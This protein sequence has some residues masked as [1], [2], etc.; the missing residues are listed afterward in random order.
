[1]ADDPAASDLDGPDASFPPSP[2]ET[3][4]LLRRIQ[5]GDDDA[6]EALLAKMLPRLRRWAHGRLPNA[7]RGMLDTGDIV[8]TVAAKALKQLAHL[9]VRQQGCVGFYLRQAVLNEIA[10]QWRRAGRKPFET[11]LSE[12]IAADDSSPL[13]Q[14]LGAERLSLYEAALAALDP[15][16]RD[17]IVGRFE[18]AYN[19]DELARYLGKASAATARVTV[20]RAVKRLAEQLA[21]DA[22]AGPG[23]DAQ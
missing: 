14:L 23:L 10:T 6:L 5:S 12:S 16:D 7:A 15:A 2:E 17:A 13:D 9:D 21:F 18:L 1:V 19:Y 3:I 8:Q 22:G 20:H 4:V 11:T